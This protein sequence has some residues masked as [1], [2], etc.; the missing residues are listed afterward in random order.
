VLITASYV[1]P[2]ADPIKVETSN[3]AS[4][5]VLSGQEFI[6]ATQGLLYRRV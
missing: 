6:P 3:A 4:N 1:V 2:L 5:V